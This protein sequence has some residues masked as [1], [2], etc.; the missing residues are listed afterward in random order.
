MSWFALALSTVCLLSPL[1][2]FT[3]GIASSPHDLEAQGYAVAD[4]PGETNMCSFCHLPSMRSGK[5]FTGAGRTARQEFG[6]E[7]LLCFSCHDGL[8]I[9]S[10][11]VDASNTAFHPA[12]HGMGRFENL[13]QGDA[14]DSV[15]VPSRGTRRVSCL[16]CHQPHDDS[17]RPFLSRPMPSLC[18]ACHVGRVNSG[19][20]EKNLEGSHPIGTLPFDDSGGPSPID[21]QPEFRIL[22]PSIYP[23][24]GG[25]GAG[26]SVHWTLG[27]HLEDGDRGKLLCSTC[28]AV[29][30]REMVAPTDDY[31]V[32][33][34]IGKG[35]SPLCEGCHRG[36]RG[37]GREALSFPNP[38]GTK[39][40]RTYHPC[41]DDQGNGEGWA[42]KVEIP[43]GWPTIPSDGRVEPELLSCPTCHRAHN[44][45][46]GTAILR[47]PPPKTGF[48]ETCH[49]EVP[50]PHGVFEGTGDLACVKPATPGGG[51]PGAPVGCWSCHRAHNAGYGLK[52]ESYLPLLREPAN[53]SELCYLCHPEENPTCSLPGYEASH[54]LGDPTISETYGKSNPA[55][56]TTPWPQTRLLSLYGGENGK[57]VVCQS[58]HSLKPEALVSGDNSTGHL[59]APAGREREWSIGF[60]DQYLCAGCHGEQPATVGQ[61]QTHPLM[62]T[63]GMLSNG[64]T[65]PLVADDPI[66]FT[67]GKKINCETCH[68]AHN[69][70]VEGGYYILRIVKSSNKDAKAVHPPVRANELCRK[71]HREK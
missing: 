19:V 12:S 69:A 33:P 1:R 64:G 11:A 26:P 40:A 50:H 66:V 54:F 37:D 5:G 43:E 32:T 39:T 48:C 9:V 65:M 59:L 27:G 60:P 46:G 25:K 6:E 16:S 14:V 35:L 3:A 71:C 41:D 57:E 31:L 56:K 61:G 62:L 55:E 24:S 70:P 68:L 49:K 7:G 13:P 53:A 10:P 21:L 2:G 45:W 20:G 52:E 29:H 67:S 34:L 42:L 58:C 28:H 15:V 22:F 51:Q 17:I 44:A 30:G 4:L 38:G 63:D 8:T 18:P 36:K 23:I 47:E